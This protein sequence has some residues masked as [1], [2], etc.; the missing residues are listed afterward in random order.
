[1]KARQEKDKRK[2]PENKTNNENIARARACRQLVANYPPI[3]MLDK[4]RP[5]KRVHFSYTRKHGK[6]VRQV[7]RIG[8]EKQ[9][10]A[11]GHNKQASE[12]AIFLNILAHE[13]TN[14]RKREIGNFPLALFV[15]LRATEAGTRSR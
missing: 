15:L 3:G 7:K 1:M 4:F 5:G 10:V 8:E 9:K 6:Q 2:R 11:S 13:R 14:E 12:R